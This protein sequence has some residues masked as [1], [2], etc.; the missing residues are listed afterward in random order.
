MLPAAPTS[1]HSMAT[2]GRPNNCPPLVRRILSYFPWNNG[3]IDLMTRAA[4]SIKLN[5]IP[6]FPL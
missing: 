4:A 3:D 5:A 2:R 6:N 1:L